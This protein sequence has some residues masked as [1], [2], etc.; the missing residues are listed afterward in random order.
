[1]TSAQHLHLSGSCGTLK[2]NSRGHRPQWHGQPS[3]ISHFMGWVGTV[4]MEMDWEWLQV[5]PLYADVWAYLYINI[6]NAYCKRARLLSCHPWFLSSSFL[7]T[8]TLT[9]KMIVLEGG[10]EGQQL[11][12][13]DI[14]SVE[15]PYFTGQKG[16][17][18]KTVQ[19][20]EIVLYFYIIILVCSALFQDEGRNEKFLKNLKNFSVI[21]FL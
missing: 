21:Y 9:E 10:D 5:A 3:H 18:T 13:K 17:A 11:S 20:K 1:M 4:S 7:L 12:G 2:E 8:E 14:I 6:L 19:G 15:T 16:D